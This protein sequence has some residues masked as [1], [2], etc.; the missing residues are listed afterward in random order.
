[1]YAYERGAIANTGELQLLIDGRR[2]ALDIKHAL[3]AQYATTS[4]LQAVLNHLEIL[5][6][7][8]LITK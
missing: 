8:G 1:M 7:A 2:S 6:L 3:D 4:D 5:E